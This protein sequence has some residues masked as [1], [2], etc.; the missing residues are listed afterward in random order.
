MFR[1]SFLDPL[2]ESK[3]FLVYICQDLETVK[4]SRMDEHAQGECTKSCMAIITSH[5]KLTQKSIHKN[6]AAHG[7]FRTS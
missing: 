4:L 7:V 6:R 3:I 1:L 2:F 5:E